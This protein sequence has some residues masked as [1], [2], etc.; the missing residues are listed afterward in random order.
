MVR[1]T[2]E[3]VVVDEGASAFNLSGQC[4][5]CQLPMNGLPSWTRLSQSQTHTS[6]S[7]HGLRHSVRP[8]SAFASASPTKVS[9]AASSVSLRPT[10]AEML[11][12]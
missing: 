9:V 8:R 3:R 7:T 1:P 2:L 4:E 12:E 11:P 10:R 5:R 6:G